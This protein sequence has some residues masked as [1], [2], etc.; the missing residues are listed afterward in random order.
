MNRL[1]SSLSVSLWGVGKIDF[2]QLELVDAFSDGCVRPR[3]K[4]GAHAISHGAEPQIEACRLDLALDKWIF[5]QDQACVGHRR[6]HA[7]GQNTIGVGRER[8]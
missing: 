6:N 5:R 4:A 8:E 2:V 3:Q 7:V 1:P